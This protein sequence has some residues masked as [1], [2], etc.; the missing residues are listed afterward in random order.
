MAGNSFGLLFRVT[1]F[2]ESHGLAL[3]AVVDGCPP[4]LEISEADLQGD[5]DRR[6]PG[7]SRY[8]TP[9]REPDEVKILSG[10]F[11][12]KTTGTSIGLL[13]ENTDQRSKDYS[14]I[15][16]LFRPGHADYTYHQKYGQRD[17]RG[18]GRSSA[19]ETAMRVAAG[20]IA[21]KYL[22]QVHGIEITGFLSQLG[23]IKAEAFDAAQI[24]QNPFFFPD[25]GKLEELDQYMRDLK[26]EGNS[27]GAKVQVIARH[28]PVGL[29]EPVFDRLDADIA[30]AMMGI[31]AVK[32]VEIGDGFAVVE[33][34][35]SDHRDE[36]T[37]AGFAS[38]H[39]GGI[40]G[41][42]SSGQDIVVSMA[43]KPTSS[44][45]V[46]GKTIN[47]EG[48]AIEMI[49]KGRHDP[50]VGIR[51]VPIAEAMLALVLMDH[52]LRHRGQNQGVL[53]QTPQL[54]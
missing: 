25:A 40:L 43:L 52:L 37:P 30:H 46:P 9:R 28:V 21:K 44:I 51:A 14:E 34:K 16:D 18:G 1:T 42:I 20:A 4:G 6:K 22:K 7:T 3:G 47:T 5:L 38:N 39:A 15:K 32:G 35:G 29:G 31:N 36:M 26:K 27:I 48:E 11:E 33:Q 17:Y 8:T 24:E 12:G 50:C 2:G 19:R 41:G 54:R 45:T 13:I 49:T 10:V 53:T 23:P